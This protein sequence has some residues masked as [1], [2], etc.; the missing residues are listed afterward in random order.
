[1]ENL[2]L[3]AVERLDRFVWVAKVY[4][5]IFVMG[6]GEIGTEGQPEGVM[7]RVK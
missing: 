7:K 2:L 3:S 1:M 5:P 6:S 4:R